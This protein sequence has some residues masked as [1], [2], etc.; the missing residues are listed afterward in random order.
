MRQKDSPMKLLCQYSEHKVELKHQELF[1]Q[2]I[3]VKS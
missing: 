1:K 3:F 2:K